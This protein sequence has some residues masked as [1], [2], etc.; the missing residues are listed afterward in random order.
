MLIANYLVQLVELLVQ[1]IHS[2]YGDTLTAVAERHCGLQELAPRARSIPNLLCSTKHHSL[3]SCTHH[4]PPMGWLC[5]CCHSNT[6]SRFQRCM[7][8]TVTHPVMYNTSTSDTKG[9]RL[10]CSA[11]NIYM[12]TQ[13]GTGVDLRHDCFFPLTRAL[14]GCQGWVLLQDRA[15]PFRL[16]RGRPWP[17]CLPACG[18]GIASH[19]AVP[20]CL[21]L[22]QWQEC[23]HTYAAC[24]TASSTHGPA[25]IGPSLSCAVQCSYG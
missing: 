21:L 19:A 12:M 14:E 17:W 6:L 13:A 15:G 9:L 2:L 23:T 7:Y 22:Q 3:S 10:S 20:A 16:D 8:T 25:R 1:Q 4:Y 18:A 11:A 24:S 5:C